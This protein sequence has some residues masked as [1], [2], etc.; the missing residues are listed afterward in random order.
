MKHPFVSLHIIVS[1]LC[2]RQAARNMKRLYYLDFCIDLN[3][4]VLL[5]WNLLLLCLKREYIF[6]EIIEFT[7]VLFVW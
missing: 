7:L 3:F 6:S 4:Y 5:R 1:N 2:Y